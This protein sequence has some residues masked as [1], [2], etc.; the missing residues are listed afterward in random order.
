MQW[1]VILFTPM[2]PGAGARAAVWSRRSGHV[3]YFPEWS[4]P[5]LGG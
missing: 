2:S 3:T 5:G 4:P 1:F